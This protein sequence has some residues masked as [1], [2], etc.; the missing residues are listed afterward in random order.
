MPHEI[1]LASPSSAIHDLHAGLD[2]ATKRESKT[3]TIDIE[4]RVRDSGLPQPS[5]LVKCFLSSLF[6]QFETTRLL[7]DAYVV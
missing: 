2:T 5:V 7:G 6:E 4:A 3:S 1:N